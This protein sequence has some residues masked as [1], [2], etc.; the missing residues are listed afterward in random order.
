MRVLGIARLLDDAVQLLT[1]VALGDTALNPPTHVAPVIHVKP[2]GTVAAR[3]V[4]QRV[5]I[6][7]TMERTA[8][9]ATCA[10]FWVVQARSFVV[11]T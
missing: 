5:P 11:Q 1:Y 3:I 4:P 6:A 8:R 7:A 10:S 9:P 2:A